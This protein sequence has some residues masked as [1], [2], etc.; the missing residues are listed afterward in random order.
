MDNE[1]FAK[2][3]E[4]Q[5]RKFAVKIIRLLTKFTILVCHNMNPRGLKIDHVTPQGFM[6]IKGFICYKHFTPT[7]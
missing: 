7:G 3:L 5:T 1:E 2:E 4:K 6:D